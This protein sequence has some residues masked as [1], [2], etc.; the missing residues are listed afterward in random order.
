MKLLLGCSDESSEESYDKCSRMCLD[1]PREK[2]VVDLLINPPV[3]WCENLHGFSIPSFLG[4][5]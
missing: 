4:S 2:S 5:N 1:W 3:S